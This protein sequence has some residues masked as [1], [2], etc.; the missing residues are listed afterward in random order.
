MKASL[1]IDLSCS[2]FILN[3]PQNWLLKIVKKQ[4][5]EFHLTITNKGNICLVLVNSFHL[6]PQFL[7]QKPNPQQNNL[8]PGPQISLII[9]PIFN[10]FQSLLSKGS[11]TF[12]PFIRSKFKFYDIYLI[13]GLP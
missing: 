2:L 4:K 3:Q 10:L 6:P 11:H 9:L 13:V 1:L 12:S 8:L 5:I 7:L